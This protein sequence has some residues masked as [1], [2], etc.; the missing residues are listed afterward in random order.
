LAVVSSLLGCEFHLGSKGSP[1]GG[2]PTPRGL[3][4]SVPLPTLTAPAPRTAQIERPS[5]AALVASVD[6]AVAGVESLVEQVGATGR[7]RVVRKLEGSAFVFDASGLVL[8]NHHVID[9]AT[10]IHVVLSDERVLKAQIVGT[11]PPTDVAV[12]RVEAN[13]LPALPLGDSDATRVGDWVVAIGNPFGLSHTVSAGIVSARGRTQNDV[14]GLGTGNQ[15]FDF[16]QTDAS[17]N[18]GNSGGPLLDLEGRV[19]GINTAIRANANSIGFAIPVNMVKELLPSL[20]RDGKVTRSALG[21]SVSAPGEQEVD[22][23]NPATRRGAVVRSVV[24]GGPSD[25]AGLK[26]GDVIVGFESTPIEGP[27]RLRW[28]ASMAGVGRKVTL[29]VRRQQRT[30]DLAVTLGSLP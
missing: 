24:P 4:S 28:K 8:T 9:G 25:L 11:D 29:S 21:V 1:D 22:P 5:F 12:L 20:L 13:G 10:D 7:R 2:A 18:P 23:G 14:E 26:A 30:F 15:Y 27:E 17:I 3:G 6:P 16:L 19:V